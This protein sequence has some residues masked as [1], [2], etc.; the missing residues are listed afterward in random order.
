MESG[1]EVKL[2]LLAEICFRLD[3]PAANTGRDVKSLSFTSMTSR[4][5]SLSMGG[6]SFR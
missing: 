6:I 2:L 5:R 1:N 3:I 4:S